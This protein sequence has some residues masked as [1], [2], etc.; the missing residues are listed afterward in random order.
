M[1]ENSGNEVKGLQIIS[2][3]SKNLYAREF[4]TWRKLLL[5]HAL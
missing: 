5:I 3:T 4:S 2:G 1:R